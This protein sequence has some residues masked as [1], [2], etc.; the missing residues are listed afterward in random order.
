[1]LRTISQRYYIQQQP[2]SIIAGLW[3]PLTK[4]TSLWVR[5]RCMHCTH[6]ATYSF[7]CHVHTSH[8]HRNVFV[9]M[10]RAHFAYTSQRIRLYVTCT[11]HMHIATYSFVCHVHTSHAH[12]NVFVCMPRAHF[13]YTSQRI[14]CMPREHMVMLT[15]SAFHRI[16]TRRFAIRSTSILP[17]AT[18]VSGHAPALF[19]RKLTVAAERQ[20]RSAHSVHY[21]FIISVHRL[22][23]KK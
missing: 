17:A 14:R 11:L 22:R 15:S 21:T 7:A 23:I 10:S 9:F 2:I 20:L 5:L 3:S 4:L 19:K 13:A 18:S 16:S 1:M 8:V 6:I 12:R